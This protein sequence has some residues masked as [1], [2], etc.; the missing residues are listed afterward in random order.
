MKTQNVLLFGGGLDSTAL[1]L[2]L[3]ARKINFTLVH[4]YYNQ[5]AY[6][7]EHESAK[8]WCEKYSIPL[9][10]LDADFGFSTAT[11]LNGSQIGTKETNKLELR[12]LVFISMAASYIASVADV[13]TIYLGFHEEPPASGFQ[14]AKTHYLRGMEET[15]NLATTANVFIS[16][17]FSNLSR[18]EILAIAI[19][20]DAEI[21]THSYTCYEKEEC[22]KCVHCLE[23]A[24]MLATL[25]GNFDG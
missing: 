16:T 14:D 9:I 11:I 22:G 24:Q 3:V 10:R 25:K 13:G 2:E 7:N 18:Q 20:R 1:L 21:V 4:V 8:Y 15:I 23:K 12:N 19:K 6:K 17:P 5:K